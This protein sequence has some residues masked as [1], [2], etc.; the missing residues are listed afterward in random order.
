MRLVGF[1][2]IRCGT[3]CANGALHNDRGRAARGPSVRM[4]WRINIVK[5]NGRDL[6]ALF[7]GAIRAVAKAGVVL[8]RSPAASMPP[9]WKPPLI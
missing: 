7:N 4:R 6:E 2:A 5:L 3:G 1:N 9:I 8:P